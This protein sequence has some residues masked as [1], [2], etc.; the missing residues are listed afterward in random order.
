MGQIYD[1]KEVLK[2]LEALYTYPENHIR[3]GH[4]SDDK[5]DEMAVEIIAE[6]VKQDPEFHPELLLSCFS[7]TK[8]DLDQDLFSKD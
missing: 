6:Y 1:R 7:L 8:I 4:R 2:K 3:L 5:I